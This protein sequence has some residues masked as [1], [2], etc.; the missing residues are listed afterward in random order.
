M[1]DF[2]QSRRNDGLLNH[3][4]AKKC[5]SIKR[6][7]LRQFLLQNKDEY[8]ALLTYRMPAQCALFNLV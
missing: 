6:L 2:E 1:E 7:N 5:E 3:L 4:M 8:P